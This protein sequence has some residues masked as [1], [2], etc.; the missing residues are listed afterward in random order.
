MLRLKFLLAVGLVF[1]AWTPVTAKDKD[2]DKS[3]Q[4]TPS[5]DDFKEIFSVTQGNVKIA[6]RALSYT[7]TTGNLI[8]KTDDGKPKA[9]IFFIAYSKDGVKDLSKRSITFCT[10][11]GP[12]SS[13]VWLHMGVFGPRRVV[14]DDDGM[15]YPP[16]QL[17]DNEYSL[18]DVTDLVFIDPV[19]AGFSRPAPGEDAKQFHGVEEDVKVVAD[20]IRLYLTRYHRW[21]SPKF[22]AGESYGTT[23]AAALAA[24]L[25]NDE[26]IYLN[27]VILI[28]SVLSFQSIDF[29]KGND[30]P[31][32][33]YLPTYAATAWY[34]KRLPE[35][36]Q[37][38]TLP[39][40]LKEVEA[41]TINEY[42]PA[43]M[44]GDALSQQERAKMVDRL[45]RYTGL[46]STYISQANLRV[47][48]FRFSKELLRDKHRTVGRFDSRYIGIDSDAA[49]ENMEY[50]PSADAIFGAF[51]ASFNHYLATELGW[52]SDK[53]YEIIANVFPW[54]WGKHNNA[55]LNV[56]ESL[57]DVMTRNPRLKVFVGNG[58]YD[59]ATPYFATYQT[60]DHLG[61]DPS[62]RPNVTMRDY[63]GGHMMYNYK[64]SLAKLKQDLA[65]FI[66]NAAQ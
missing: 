36:L 12:G 18:L 7:A 13:A 10:N 8:I 59:L 21:E 1:L 62:L 41:F 24:E 17:T 56:S 28:S 11:G 15:A 33:V 34:H 49:G 29:D 65:T 40:V 54:S 30:L 9:S 55:Y 53:K 44:K 27:G 3:K 14:L 37:N 50:D 45:A 20:F 25:H 22:F 46:S 57:R 47:N 60:F 48:Q 16:Y 63:I 35:D 64:P 6:G 31:Y 38:K 19:S 52:H 4:E 66:N 26:H 23:R 5:S 58:F 51:T 43:L 42:A 39:E 2:E 32:I 61:L